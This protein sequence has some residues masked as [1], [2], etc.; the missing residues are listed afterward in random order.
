MNRISMSVLAFAAAANLA[1]PV[2]AQTEIQGLHAFTGRRVELPNARVE[3]F[4][5]SQSADKVVASRTGNHSEALNVGIAAVRAKEQPQ[6][7]QAF[8]VG[9]ATMRAAKGAVRPCM[10]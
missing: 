5:A 9:T 7:L 3:S 1:T 10:G 2:Q 6:I 4:N 8:E